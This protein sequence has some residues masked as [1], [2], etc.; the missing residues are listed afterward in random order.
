MVTV[1]AVDTDAEP[2]SVTGGGPDEGC[3]HS[4]WAPMIGG[5]TGALASSEPS[6]STDG[7]RSIKT[8]LKLLIRTVAIRAS[9]SSRTLDDSCIERLDPKG[10]PPLGPKSHPSHRI[11]P[12]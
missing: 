2:L 8:V 4:K 6:R 5:H 10:C 12:T 11:S 3:V 1:A 9:N 7:G